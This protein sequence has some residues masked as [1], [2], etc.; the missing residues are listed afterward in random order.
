MG[1]RESERK[2]T[3]VRM[4]LFKTSFP[5]LCVKGGRSVCVC[6]CVCV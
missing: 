3:A 5:P 2:G 4:K 6:V 1:G